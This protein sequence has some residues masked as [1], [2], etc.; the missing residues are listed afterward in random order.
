VCPDRECR[1]EQ[2]KRLIAQPRDPR[3]PL[4]ER[5]QALKQVMHLTRDPHPPL[6]AT[7]NGCRCQVVAGSPTCPGR[8]SAAVDSVA[9]WGPC[10][11][12]PV[13][14]RLGPQSQGV[15]SRERR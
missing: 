13:R 2:L 7:D 3:A 4:R 14:A 10:G 5:G 15:L 8:A 12:R 6:R 1:S 11:T 9:F